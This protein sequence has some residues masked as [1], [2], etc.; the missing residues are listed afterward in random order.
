MSSNLIPSLRALLM[1]VATVLAGCAGP[2]ATPPRPPVPQSAPVPP[3]DEVAFRGSEPNYSIQRVHFGTNRAPTGKTAPAEFFGGER[4]EKIIYGVCE[5]SIP[6]DHRMGELESPSIW[7][8]EFQ[9]DP[10][11]H[12]V[13]A[14]V[15]T[16]EAAAFFGDLKIRLAEQEGKKKAFV[17]IHGFNVSFSEAARRTAQINY[18]LGFAGA[19]LF[20]SWPSQAQL[21][22]YRED[23]NK[24]RWAAPHLEAFLGDLASKLDADEIYVIAHSM[25]NQPATLALGAL[26]S[27]RPELA[28]R[29]KEIILMAPDVDAEVFKREIAPPLLSAGRHVTLYASSKDN[30]LKV[31]KVVNGAQRLGDADPAIVVLPGMESID[32]S[33]VDTDL[34]GHSYYADARSVVSDLFEVIRDKGTAAARSH[35]EEIVSSIGRFWRFKPIVPV[36]PAVAKVN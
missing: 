9:P 23:G 3:P 24:A 21:L 14:K 5:V 13:L 25:G 31:S 36:S 8:L 34:L 22:S 30:A 27:A 4:G 19:P 16:Q 15:E 7:R 6:R 1:A 2:M 29:F 12:V 33:N 26:F 18:D 11:K 28:A 32:A 20:F 10:N 35:L 17:F